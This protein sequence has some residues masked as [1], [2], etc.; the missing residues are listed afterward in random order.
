MSDPLLP[1]PKHAKPSPDTL[2]K[3]VKRL[4]ALTINLL[5]VQVHPKE[6]NEPTSR[7]ITPQVI[8]AYR[9]SAGDFEEALPYCLLRAR[10]EFMWDADQDAADYDENFG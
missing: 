3:L 4:R 6:L 7:I 5:P 9:A 10:A 1:P 8:S 2:T